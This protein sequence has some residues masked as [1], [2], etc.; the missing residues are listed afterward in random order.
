MPK[1]ACTYSDRGVDVLGVDN[2]LSLND[3]EV[4]KLLDLVDASR[5]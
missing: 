3:E 4:E 1:G 5:N 2:A